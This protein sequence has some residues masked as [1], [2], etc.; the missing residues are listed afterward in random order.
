M[1]TAR[2]KT[3]TVKKHCRAAMAVVVI[4]AFLCNVVLADVTWAR[5]EAM[6][7]GLRALA[8]QEARGGRGLGVEE[9]RPPVSLAEMRMAEMRSN[10]MGLS[11]EPKPMPAPR[12]A[13]EAITVI[14][15]DSLSDEDLVMVGEHGLD[16]DKGR[17]PE[18]IPLRKSIVEDLKTV[19]R[20]LREIGLHLYVTKGL[21]TLRIQERDI[22][23]SI[24]KWIPINLGKAGI[25]D[26]SDQQL[27]SIVEAGFAIDAY[28][29]KD[30]TARAGIKGARDTEKTQGKAGALA[31]YISGI[32]N[33]GL[34]TELKITPDAQET[35][36][37]RQDVKD[38]V[39]ATLGWAFFQHQDPELGASHIS[40][41]AFDVEIRNE[42]NKPLMTKKEQVV[43]RLKS[44]GKAA[45]L[46]LPEGKSALDALT[47]RYGELEKF[48]KG[49]DPR[50][51][52][53][54][55]QLQPLYDCLWEVLRNRRFLYHLLTKSTEE[56]GVL[57]P[58]HTFVAHPGEV[59][60]F[61]RGDTTSAVFAG[62][63]TAIYDAVLWASIAAELLRNK[64]ISAAQAQTIADEINRT[65]LPSLLNEFER[66]RA[67]DEAERLMQE[68][69]LEGKIT[70]DELRVFIEKAMQLG[71]VS[72]DPLD[73]KK[74][75]ERAAEEALMCV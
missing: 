75:E 48:L 57:K 49:K 14:K 73:E 27:K 46:D 1:K 4:A 21:V 70:V 19:D 12:E 43:E 24:R 10:F 11:A 52:P 66:R 26:L 32:L 69:Y 16:W 60:H 36:L 63:E 20:A 9:K 37:S 15:D 53:Q 74:Q 72:L 64:D 29:R 68:W 51:P 17:E 67:A 25:S 8:N 22:E 3:S 55:P 28:L 59:W 71:K 44:E 33:K 58:G 18:G 30:T 61:G 45:I 38:V 47:F 42:E 41:A 6:S 34:F 13:R 65:E 31:E 35:L 54:D 39:A 56:G 50:G 62:S 23:N 5:D 2:Y 7:A 40:G